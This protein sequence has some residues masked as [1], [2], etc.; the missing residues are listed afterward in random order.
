MKQDFERIL[1]FTAA[2]AL[3]CV[4]EPSP[5]GSLRMME[6]LEKM[7]L[8]GV[9]NELITGDKPACLAAKIAAEK[10]SALTDRNE[11]QKLVE[12][13]AIAFVDGI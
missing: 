4:K 3:E 8:F 7:L 6:I 5:Y 1:A 9:Q 2:S 11:F 12:D 13:V 10:G